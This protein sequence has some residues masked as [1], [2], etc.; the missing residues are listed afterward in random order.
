MNTLNT[1]ETLLF[2]AQLT[3]FTA[4]LVTLVRLVHSLITNK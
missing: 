1:L 3:I 4:F 2:G